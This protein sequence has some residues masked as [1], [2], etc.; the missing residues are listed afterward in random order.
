MAIPKENI[1]VIFIGAIVA[2][3][4][5]GYNIAKSIYVS[6]TWEQTQGV[7]VDFEKNVWSCGKNIGECYELIV[8]YHAGKDYFTVNSKKKFN[9]DPP[10][11]LMHEKVTVYYTP[12]NPAEAILGD[13]YGPMNYGKILFFIGIGV[14]FIFWIVRKRDTS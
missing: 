9:Y 5:G 8:G 13:G 14:L 11:H 6:F 12:E 1:K 2:T 10:K 7:V 4:W 3:L